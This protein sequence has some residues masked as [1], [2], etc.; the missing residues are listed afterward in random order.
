MND[1]FDNDINNVT[2]IDNIIGNN[3][4]KDM[5]QNMVEKMDIPNLL[6]C[7]QNG[8]GKNYILNILINN[9]FKDKKNELCMYLSINDERGISTVREKIKVFSNNKINNY[10]NI[11]KYKVIIFDQ[12]DYITIDA[13]NALRRI[14]EKSS[15]LTRFIFLCNNIKNII[16]PICSRFLILNINSRNI[17][18]KLNFYYKRLSLNKSQKEIIKNILNTSNGDTRKEIRLIKQMLNTKNN[19]IIKSIHNQKKIS[20]REYINFYK[21]MQKTLTI[22]EIKNLINEINEKYEQKNFFNYFYNF[23][24]DDKDFINKKELIDITFNYSYNINSGTDEFL[25]SLTYLK[26]LNNILVN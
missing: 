14:I 6:I 10:E 13:Q 12:A 3:I 19:K 8:C 16:E 15:T 24:L 5:I 7:G 2:K 1:I 11:P 21:K 18:E 25:S 4:V 9:L 17:E 20:N 26:N 23:L 22:V